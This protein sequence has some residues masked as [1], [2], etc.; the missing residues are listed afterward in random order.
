[1]KAEVSV[2]KE[3]DIKSCLIKAEVRY[4]EDGTVNGVEDTNGDLIP[5]RKGDLWC[6]E[7]DIETGRILNWTQGVRADV[8]YKIC[9][10]G[11]YYLKDAEGN[12]VLSI[13]DDYVPNQL[14]PG[15]YGD[16]IEM[17]INE[18][19]MII[20]WS[21]SPSFDDFCSEKE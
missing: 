3:V 15:S 10:A 11:S 19:G 20:N 7:I 6:P 4:W 21:A 13:E 1:M 18:Q 5:C 16:Y 8:H 14:I 12:T 17:H 2:K 9:D